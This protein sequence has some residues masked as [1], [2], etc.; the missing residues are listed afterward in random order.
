METECLALASSIRLQRELSRV[1]KFPYAFR[2]VSA[3]D[4]MYPLPSPSS[5]TKR[6]AVGG[7][8]VNASPA[9][10]QVA[11]TQPCSPQRASACW[12]WCCPTVPSGGAV[13]IGGVRLMTNNHRRLIAALR[14]IPD[15][16]AET[17]IS[18]LELL[19]HGALGVQASATQSPAAAEVEHQGPQSLVDPDPAA[20]ATRP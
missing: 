3:R 13:T 18:R 10:Y 1:I 19:S 11:A 9:T 2:S 15:D 6:E 4:K 7:R 16:V 5:P 12:C 14:A 20:M 17:A 8:R